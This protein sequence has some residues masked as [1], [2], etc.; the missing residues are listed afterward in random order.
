MA[1]KEWVSARISDISHELLALSPKD[2][3]GAPGARLRSDQLFHEAA[4]EVFKD[5]ED[6]TAFNLG[7]L[8]AKS[9]R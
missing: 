3:R 4:A 8:N 9:T 2:K 7:A 1:F 6:E 5:F